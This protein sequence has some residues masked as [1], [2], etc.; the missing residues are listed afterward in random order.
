MQLKIAILAAFFV[1]TLVFS[2]TAIAASGY[3]YVGIFGGQG[4]VKTGAF[5]YPQYTAV[6]ETGNVYVTDLGN[7]RVQK[8]DNDG[9]FLH[10][11]GSKG[12]GTY[13][14]HAPAGIAVGA[15]YVYVSDHELNF[16]KK[17]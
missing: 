13:E 7:A 14:F 11:W 16:V 9:E 5:T 2:Q 8:F 4:L 3:P 1:L 10:S 15:G 6:D 17:F 12:T